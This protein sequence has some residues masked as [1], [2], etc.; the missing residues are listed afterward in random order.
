MV[1]RQ[2]KR[3]GAE[4]SFEEGEPMGAELDN[5]DGVLLVKV[6]G[7][8]HAVKDKCT[9]YGGPLS[10]GVVEEEGVTCPWHTALFELK[11]GRMS[12]AP[13]LDDLPRYPVKVVDGDVYVGEEQ[14][15]AV[16]AA[17]GEDGR[18]FAI[19]GGGAAAL[20][21]AEMLRREG[22]AGRVVMVTPEMDRPYDRPN[23]SKAFMSGDAPAG[24]IPL[25]GE[26]WYADLRLE[27]MTGRR[28]DRLDAGGRTLVLDGGE[29]LAYDELLLATGG[30]PRPLPVPGADL[31]NV[32]T[33]RSLK[34][35]EA[36]AARADDSEIAVVIGAG[37]IGLEVAAS[38]RGRGLQVHLVA[39]EK[40]PMQRVFGERVGEWLRKLHENAGVT[41][42]MGRDVQAVVGDERV[43]AVEMDGGERVP[44][45]MVVTGLGI[46]PVV[47]YLE[48]TDL[49]E[50]GAVAV[51]G[52]L[53][54]RAAHV[55]AA[56]DIAA[57]PDPF[58]RRRRRVEHWTVAQRQGQHAARAMLG[59]DEDY[60]M[61]PFF[62]TRQFG[63][64]LQYAGYAPE[65]DQVVHRGEVEEGDFLAGYYEQ[66]VLRAV[67]GC[68]HARDVI[69]LAREIERGGNVLPD[70]FEKS[71]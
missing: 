32:F 21:C 17:R 36:I 57:V 45:D 13:A 37:F 53:A 1:D 38:L 26:G 10:E 41:M 54:T 22:F 8:I 27:V 66:G 39:P 30:A 59:S 48:G 24:W 19:A 5:G 28:V 49:V 4:K 47:D 34:D 40:T 25:R 43:T 15:V 50:D 58:A 29:T 56:G 68:G 11:S 23:L 51:D 64:S 18:T 62:W 55:Y 16:P 70:R 52:R 20:A 35:A 12:R 2:W 65:F 42:H 6:D 69:R 33:L 71:S 63:T 14:P 46:E 7:R 67:S 3:V 61:A 60:R 9:H 44:A 31:A